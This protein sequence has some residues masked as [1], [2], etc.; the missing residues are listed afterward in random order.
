[1][2]V[3]T[4]NLG[5]RWSERHAALLME[6]ACDVWLLTEVRYD[7]TVEGY[8]LKLTDALMSQRRHWA[9]VLVSESLE[10]S[11]LPDPHPATAVVEAEGLAFASSVLPWRSAGDSYPPPR[12]PFADKVLKVLAGLERTLPTGG[13]VWGGDW[14]QALAGPELAGSKAG[15][16][17]LRHT[18]E[19]LSLQVAT[20]DLPHQQDGL[21]AIDHIAVPTEAVV[22]RAARV[23]ALMNG[24][25]LSDHD[26]Y[27]VEIHPADTAE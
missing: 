4:W 15:R 10:W 21:C 25:W 23:S 26:A 3:G 1:M 20:A 12:M 19:A 24:A 11:A 8:G 22:V 7:L 14:N 13:L 9:A 5:G 18:L 27:V 2:W 17:R 6:Q 16:V